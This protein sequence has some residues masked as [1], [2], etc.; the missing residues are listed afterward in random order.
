MNLHRIV[1]SFR[2]RPRLLV[3]VALG[4][5][6]SVVVPDEI[7]ISLG[8]RILV[9]WNVCAVLYF[10][11]ALHLIVHSRCQH[12]IENAVEQDDGAL[13]VLVLVILASV[14]VLSAV[15]TQL[16]GVRDLHGPAR[17]WHIGLAVLTVVS[18]WFFTQTSF[19]LHY[20]HDF[21]MGRVRGEPDGLQFP[22][23]TDPTYID[24]LYFAC[25]IGTS[26]QT[27]DVSMTTSAMRAVGGVHCVQAFFF[28]TT[29]L[30]LAI[31]IAAGLF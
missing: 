1:R 13:T 29:V 5:L 20:A 27:A 23:T 26:G 16:A 2:A 7:A 28:N 12:I 18:S 15:G 8:T 19:A 25:V 6:A 31:N 30:A 4:I 22:G 14:A 17:S 10:A 3:C 24:F 21:F 9:G 11:L